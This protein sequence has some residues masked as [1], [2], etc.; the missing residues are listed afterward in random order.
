M[1]HSIT[2]FFNYPAP[3]ALTNKPYY[4]DTNSQLQLKDA[5]KPSNTS[6]SDFVPPPPPT[7]F[8]D[9]SAS[10]NHTFFRPRQTPRRFQIDD[11][12]STSSHHDS[13]QPATHHDSIPPATHHDSIPPATHHT[14]DIDNVSTWSDISEPTLTFGNIYRDPNEVEPAV[15]HDQSQEIR[16]TPI[17][18]N[19]YEKN[20]KN[21]NRR[22]NYKIKTEPKRVEKAKEKGERHHMLQED[23]YSKKREKND[24][25]YPERADFLRPLAFYINQPPPPK[26]PSP[27]R[28]IG[29]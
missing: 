27:T 4:V 3:P 25:K 11:Y 8:E 9:E 7:P 5:D 22:I 12:D 13:I 16:T 24:E 20:I 17:L 1:P 23:K 2:P 19:V 14:D 26:P 29:K 28:K 15:F 10:P 6:L 21:A 18:K